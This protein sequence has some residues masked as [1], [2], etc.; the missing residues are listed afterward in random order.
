MAC[1]HTF[2]NSLHF[3]WSTLHHQI[4]T[5]QI[6]HKEQD[7]IAVTKCKMTALQSCMHT[8]ERL[9]RPA[10]D[11]PSWRVRCCVQCG[12]HA[13]A[14]LPNLI[15]FFFICYLSFYKLK[16]FP[17]HLERLTRTWLR[18]ILGSWSWIYSINMYW[19]P[20]MCQVLI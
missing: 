5:L 13:Y 20:I 14:Q 9:L 8:L 11:G 1:D 2:L 3:F 15:I 17:W 7:S 18:I 12:S 19:P 16:L 10:S 4:P 6:L